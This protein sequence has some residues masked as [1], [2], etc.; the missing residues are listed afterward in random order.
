MATSVDITQ[1]PMDIEQGAIGEVHNTTNE[2][3]VCIYNKVNVARIPAGESRVYPL[4][5]AVHVGK[6]LAQKMLFDRKAQEDLEGATNG[7]GKNAVV[8]KSRLHALKAKPISN[9][10]EKRWDLMKQIIKSDSEF[11]KDP[12]KYS[13]VSGKLIEGIDMSQA[14]EI[15]PLG[16]GI[17]D[18]GEGAEKPATTGKGKSKVAPALERVAETDD[19]EEDP[20]E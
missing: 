3:F 14:K 18:T 9:F 19:E 12:E 1:V 8:D 2:E 16:Q 4:N 17:A 7:S 20:E 6:H 5:I 10:R 15:A 13:H 11:F